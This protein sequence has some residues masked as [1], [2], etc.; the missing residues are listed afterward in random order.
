MDIKKPIDKLP[1]IL[2]IFP[3]NNSPPPLANKTLKKSKNTPYFKEKKIFQEKIPPCF[4]KVV[5]CLTLET[6]SLIHDKSEVSSPV[7]EPSATNLDQMF[8]DFVGGNGL[9]GSFFL[10]LLRRYWSEAVEI[11]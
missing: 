7:P 11:F 1:K 2:V 10:H 9:E 6:F 4:N 8:L 3:K 5:R